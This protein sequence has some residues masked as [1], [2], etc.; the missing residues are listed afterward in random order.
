MLRELLAQDDTNVWAM[1]E[2]T[3]VREAAGDYK[4]TFKLLVRLVDLS[5]EPAEMKELRRRA[6]VIARDKLG[7]DASAIDLFEKIFDDDPAALDAAAGAQG[8]V[9]E[10]A[11]LRRS[12]SLDRAAD[13]PRGEPRSEERAPHRARSTVRGALQGARPR[14]RGSCGRCSTSSPRTATRSCS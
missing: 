8:P 14:G 11:A 13:R 10:A 6:A 12:G 3:R 7:D 5:V 4:E 9:P 2:L 1:S